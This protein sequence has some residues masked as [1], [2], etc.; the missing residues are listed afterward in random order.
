MLHAKRRIRPAP[1]V[2]GSPDVVALIET[3]F[4]AYNAA[5]L[6]EAC[7]TFARM[8]DEGTT[9]G[10]SL[11]GALTP[12]GLSSVLVP[13]I[14]RGYIDYISSTGANLYHDLHFDLDLPL[15]RG[16][17]DV[18]TGAHDVKLRKDGI[19]RVYDVLFP[20][21]VLYRTDEWVY[22]VLMA[23]EF[24]KELSGSQL[25]HGIGKYALA[26]AK[27]AGV[28]KPSLLAV[29]HQ[30]DMPIWVASPGD[31]TIG[32][33][34]SAIHTAFPEKAPKVDP[35]ADVMEMAALV[36]DAK[37]S[38]NG[39]SGVLIFGGGAPKNFLLQ[40]EPQ[41]QEILGVSEK[42]HDYFIQI[43]DARPDTGGLSG[44]T[45]AEAVSWGKIDP[46]KLPDTVVCYVDSTVVMP[47]MASYVLAKCKPRKPKRLY[48]RL[49]AMV[50]AMRKEYRKSPLFERYWGKQK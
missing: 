3:Y 8:I 15:Y 30:Y 45:P 29:A 38:R 35:S 21:D 16:S 14:Q 49:P 34:L 50:A 32:L 25:H 10:V 22:R 13:L 19:I 26:T 17:P 20:A 23:P 27:K 6:R 9:I 1:L 4:N 24:R 41:L 48:K 44:A 42:G 40:T 18:A 7:Q 12:A 28:K 31:S 37:R 46:D 47:L 2:K 43:T 39:T 33:N 5:R 36:L 11:S